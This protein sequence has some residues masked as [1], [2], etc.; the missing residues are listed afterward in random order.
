VADV[1]SNPDNPV[2]NTRS[3]GEDPA[4]VALM[5]A[6]YVRGAQEAG[7]IATLKHFPGHGDTRDD[8]HMRLPVLP[9]DAVRLRQVE[10][11]PF[12][13]GID[14][15]AKAV[16]TSHLAL[17]RIDPTGRPATLSSPILTGLL[18]KELGFDGI[19]VTDGMRM[20]GITDQ[21]GSEEAA[22]CALEA[23]ADAVLGI[24]DIDKGF[25]GVLS[26][27]RSGRLSGERIDASVR[28]ILAAKYW[29]GLAVRRTVPVDAIFRVVGDPESRRIS[30][31]ISDASVTLLH[32][33]KD[34]LPLSSLAKVCVVTVTQEP[35]PLVGT[36]LVDELQRHV[37]S[38]DIVR[39]S[40]ETGQER[41]TYIAERLHAV[42]V[43][44]VGIY[45]PVV[46]WRGEARFSEPLE[47]FLSSLDRQGKTVIVVA[48]GDPYILAKIPETAAVMTPYNGTYLAEESVAKAISGQI[49]TTGKLPVSIPARYP[50]G[51]GMELEPGSK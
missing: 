28:R 13:A 19:V 30:R 44:L 5:V 4:A 17:P 38:A 45:I 26:A 6:A 14:A 40:N 48:F 20:Q 34:L 23:G 43:L 25:R 36:D 31:E 1:N 16:M 18:R 33:E 24:E 15:G 12:A 39:V 27:V 8:S 32:N 2:I 11:V 3:Y 10:L 35:S 7:M 46:A 42:D 37:G 47:R 41:F 21:Y 50:R 22:V 9:F 49:A 29:V 51:W